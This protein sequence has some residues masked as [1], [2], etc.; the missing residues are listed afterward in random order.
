MTT[1]APMTTPAVYFI[2]ATTMAAKWVFQTDGNANGIAYSPEN[3]LYVDVTGISSGRPNVKDPLRPRQIMA[4]DINQGQ[5][6]LRSERLFSNSISY[7]CDGVRVSKRGLV[8]CATAD[9]VDVIEPKS[10]IT[11]GRIRIGGG[12]YVA[13]NIAFEDHILWIVGK[14]GVWKVSQIKELLRRDW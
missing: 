14:G 4:Y 9:G 11:L 2:N 6:Q 13:V 8:F 7:Y 12:S 3:T 1:F 5:P 10:G